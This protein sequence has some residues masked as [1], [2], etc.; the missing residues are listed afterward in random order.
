[1]KKRKKIE[2]LA[3][4]LKKQLKAYYVYLTKDGFEIILRKNRKNYSH[5]VKFINDNFVLEKSTDV[6]SERKIK[7]IIEKY[8][9]LNC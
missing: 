2:K 9:E 4:F 8:T 6:L 1:M 5:S 3:I 7:N